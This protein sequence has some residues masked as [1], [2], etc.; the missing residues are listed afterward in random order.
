M[1]KVIGIIL[2]AIF[3][4]VGIFLYVLGS[5]L[6]HGWVLTYLWK[7][8]VIPFFGLPILPIT[9][10]M[11]LALIVSLLTTN[12]NL[13]Y[14]KDEFKIKKGIQIFASLSTPLITLFFGWII[15]MYI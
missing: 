1:F 8:F 10:A 3:G 9:Y 7:W 5:A 6:I 14:I 12:S 15:Q 4:L 13:A 11:G 2:G